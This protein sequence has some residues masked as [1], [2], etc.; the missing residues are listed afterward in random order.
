MTE[1]NGHHKNWQM[2]TELIGQMTTKWLPNTDWLQKNWMTTKKLTIDYKKL[3]KNGQMDKGLQWL[4]R[5]DWLQKIDHW[6]IS[7]N[8]SFEPALNIISFKKKSHKFPTPY[9]YAYA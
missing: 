4:Q 8:H 1:L 2:T 3:T 7:F 6:A 5:T 9:P